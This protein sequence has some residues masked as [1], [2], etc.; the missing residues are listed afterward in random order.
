MNDEMLDK[1]A[2]SV[3]SGSRRWVALGALGTALVCLGALRAPDD[4]GA[5]KKGKGKKGGKG[6]GK[7]KGSK[8]KRCRGGCQHGATCQRGRCLCPGSSREVAE[9]LPGE[10]QQWCVPASGNP[11]IC[12]PEN[13]IYAV[14]PTEAIAPSGCSAPEAQAPD[15][16]CPESRLCGTRCCEGPFQCLDASTSTCSGAPPV[17]ARIRRRR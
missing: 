17:Y 10:D 13:R 15:V 14:C 5:R 2:L 11:K 1:L 4:A 12:C 9:C 6:K 16:C 3:A 7:G 8:R